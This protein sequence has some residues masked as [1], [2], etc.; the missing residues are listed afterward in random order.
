[1]ISYRIEYNKKPG[2]PTVIKVVKDPSVSRD[3]LY[4]SGTIHTGQG[5]SP[6]SMSRP[7]PRGK[8]VA[9]K[10][11]TKG[12]LLRPGGPGGGPSK[13]SSRPSNS[14][15]I[16]P[17]PP[18]SESQ[19]NSQPP[20][21]IPA[22]ISSQQRSVPQNPSATSEPISG[23]NGYQHSRNTSTAS[24]T[25]NAPPPPPPP[26]P[27]SAP[28]IRKDTYKAL[29]AFTGQSEIELTLKKNEVIEVLSKEGNGKYTLFQ[30]SHT[31]PYTLV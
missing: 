3:D 10:P 11:I 31:H 15:P 26:P 8:K 30:T 28:A 4:K 21:A 7:T 24:V 16:P 23:I 14:R 20:R 5:E 19:R 12:K 13:L 27:S 6:N 1:M 18:N 22:T 29:Y 17:P 9:G 2:K 25:R